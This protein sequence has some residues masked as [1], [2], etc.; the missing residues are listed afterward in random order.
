VTRRRRQL[1]VV[2]LA[3]VVGSAAAGA[4][5]SLPSKPPSAVVAAKQAAVHTAAV[6][7]PPIVP[8]IR[9]LTVGMKGCPCATVFQMQRALKAAGVRPASSRST[10]YYGKITAH[11]VAAFQKRVHIRPVTGRYGVKTHHALSKYYDRAGRARLTQVQA[12]RKRVAI[13]H[14]IVVVAAHARQVGGDTLTYS[15]SFTRNNLPTYPGV[16]PATDCSG[17]VTWVYKSVGLP[18]PSGWS[19]HPAGWT[20][21][22]SQHGLVVSAV[23]PH[24]GDLA[25]YGG[26]FPFGHVAIVV[27]VDPTLVSSHGS[28]GIHIESITY[29]PLSQLRRYF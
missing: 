16:P 29:R 23:H 5:T 9:T 19:F 13:T 21:S 6:S 20:G 18:D 28:T 24:I 22:I 15:Q 3:L 25:F 17:Y 12:S 2:G 26:G 8:F 7:T 14:A 11:Q 4:A 1:V 10:G 27:H